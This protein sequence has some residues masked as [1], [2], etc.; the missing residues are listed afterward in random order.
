MEDLDPTPPIIVLER[1]VDL[2]STWHA[3]QVELA[4]LSSAG[5]LS[6]VAGSGHMIHLYKP[7]AVAAAIREVVAR[8]R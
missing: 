3:Q 7:A 6:T 2:D 4:A 1:G 5:Q 8:A